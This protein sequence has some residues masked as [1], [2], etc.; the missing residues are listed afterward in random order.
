MAPEL[1][2]YVPLIDPRNVEYTEAID[3]W[4]LGCIIH[5]L[6]TGVVP[7]PP[8]LTL[9]LVE[10]CKNASELPLHQVP[11]SEF[12]LESLRELLTPHPARRV[13]A[14]DALTRTWASV[15]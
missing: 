15:G 6:A 4:A 10:Y 7:F 8:N 2:G 3:L 12:G 11:M 9:A 13:S 1:L 5:R 14:K